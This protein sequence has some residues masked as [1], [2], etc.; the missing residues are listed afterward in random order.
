MRCFQFSFE[1]N[2]HR[3]TV[4]PKYSQENCDLIFSKAIFI[5][6]LMNKKTTG[7]HQFMIYVE[8]AVTYVTISL[9]AFFITPTRHK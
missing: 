7:L 2:Y 6:I 4:I 9:L 1:L 8:F 5:D 3:S